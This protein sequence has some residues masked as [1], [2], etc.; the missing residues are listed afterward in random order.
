MLKKKNLKSKSQ[1]KVTF[2]L[3]KSYVGI[4]DSVNLVGDM[5]NWDMESYPMKKLKNGD[6]T[7]DLHLDNDR[8]YQ[9]R[10]H[11]NHNYWINDEAADK[12]ISS[13]FPGVDN[14]VLIT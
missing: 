6:F 1:C 11:V 14:S 4:A 12:Y 5:N 13:P 7:L 9:F 2:R 8:E 3:N 10:Y